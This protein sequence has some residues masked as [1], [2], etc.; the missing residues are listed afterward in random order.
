V[1]RY[2]YDA[3]GNLVQ[4]IDRDGQ[5]IDYTYD[6]LDRGTAE[7]WISGSTAFRTIATDYNAQGEVASVT[8]TGD[9][10][11]A[12]PQYVDYAYTYD[13]IGRLATVTS[14]GPA[15]TATVVLTAGYDGDGN[16]TSLSAA[17]EA[18][19]ASSFTPDFQNTYSYDALNEML[20]VAQSA[21]SG[22]NAVAAKS[23][24]F[25][26]D[27]DG[28]LTAVSRFQDA[29]PHTAVA[30]DTTDLVARAAYGYDGDGRLTSLTYSLP[31]GSTS[32][33]P[34]YV[35]AY[36]AAD[37]IS[38]QSSRADT[39]PADPNY[40]PS[41]PTTWARAQYNY[42]PAGQLTTS[43]VNGTT[44]HA[45]TYSANWQNAPNGGTEDYNYDANGNRDN[46]GFTVS[47][48]SS[49]TGDNQISSDGTYNYYYD[50][51]GNL[52]RQVSIA[53][54]SET[55]YSYDFRNR[56]TEVAS[57]DSS[58]RVTQV[59]DY[60]YDAFNR[61]VGRTQ[62]NYTYTGDSTTPSSTVTATG[63]FVY[64]GDNM[65]LALDNSGNV[66][67][68]VLWGPAVDQVLAEEDSSGTVTWALSDNQGTVR[69][70]AQ[71]SGGTTTVV[72][73]RVFSSF[74]QLLSQTNPSTGTPATVDSVFGYTGSYYD[75]ATGLQ[76]NLNRWYNPSLQRWMGQD[77]DGLLPDANPYRYCGDGPMDGVDAT[78]LARD[79]EGTCC[80]PPTL[81]GSS[82]A[83][84]IRLVT[85][86]Y[87][88]P[89]QCRPSSVQGM[90]DALGS[91]QQL[92]MLMT[93]FAVGEAGL[94]AESGK[95][96]VEMAKAYL[97]DKIEGELSPNPSAEEAAEKLLKSL[98]EKISEKLGYRVWVRM[99]WLS[100]E[101]VTGLAAW[102]PWGPC[103]TLVR[104]TD[105]FPVTHTGPNE[106]VFGSAA[107]DFRIPTPA[108][109]RAGVS[110]ATQQILSD[111]RVP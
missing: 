79:R 69:D 63:H 26:Y 54:G 104:H 48:P 4:S 49:S 107:V 42:D 28:E 71:Y 13:S 102:N 78:G 44:T 19:G 97:K 105:E 94:K 11:D 68:R 37:R 27:S 50:A 8:D 89:G 7:L 14:T 6:H 82:N 87:G 17:I 96:I 66:T 93:V 60:V 15:G 18:P 1:A 31:T 57:K 33:A 76:W 53:G 40:N 10:R 106:W 59:V 43:T 29:A 51:D 73:H 34:A 92:E 111:N 58:G 75:S 38:E 55:D 56:L 72:N 24:A 62:A 101:K 86:V 21:Q 80:W 90:F 41:D 46:A 36:D 5:E 30:T 88:P 81:S 16:R 61:L 74:G 70:L 9:T 39:D 83:Y 20:E 35:W 103:Y 32:T 3:D 52:T 109:I 84:D 108:D 85:V 45:V 98:A 2:A 25:G 99:T 67:D 12:S 91:V 22:G 64:D 100:C 77:P 23:A 95:R 47:A 65:V 110:A